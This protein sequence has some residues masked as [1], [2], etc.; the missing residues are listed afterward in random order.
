[1][2]DLGLGRVNLNFLNNKKFKVPLAKLQYP[3]KKNETQ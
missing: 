1:M 3:S 2:L